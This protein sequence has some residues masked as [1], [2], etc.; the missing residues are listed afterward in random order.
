M[1][2]QNGNKI[3]DAYIKV[4]KYDIGTGAYIT[5]E[6]LKTDELGK[7]LGNIILDTTWY[8][9][10]V[11]YEGDTYLT[12]S[13]TKMTSTTRTFTI[14]L[15][16]DFFDRYT[17][18]VYNIYSTLNYT[19]ETGNFAFTYSD[20]N[21]NYHQGCL[22]VERFAAYGNTLINETCV[23][24]TASTILVNVNDSGPVNGTYVAVGYVLFDDKYTLNILTKTWGHLSDVFGIEG[25]FYAFFIILTMVMV[26]VF[27][28]KLAIILGMIGLVIS[29]II[30]FM[31][32]ELGWLVVILIAAGLTM[33]RMR[34]N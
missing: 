13:A 4:M 8:R 2:D 24:S 31:F 12:T 21:G 22:R 19:D 7:A 26:G 30:G 3:E 1:L 27:N 16:T 5:I 17:D 23:S 25:L 28:P 20:P 29:N 15:L 11:E 6:V 10:I 34:D 32:V 18:V 33:Y 9:F 14:D